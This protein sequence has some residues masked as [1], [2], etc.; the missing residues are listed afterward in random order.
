S[1]NHFISHISPIFTPPSSSHP[2][3]PADLKKDDSE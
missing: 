2:Q 3:P 1:P